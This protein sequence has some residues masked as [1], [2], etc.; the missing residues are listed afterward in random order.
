MNIQM[1]V[2]ADENFA[3]KHVKFFDA[4]GAE[5]QWEQVTKLNLVRQA[6]FIAAEY[7]RQRRIAERWQAMF[8]SSFGI[9]VFTIAMGVF[10]FL[11]NG[12]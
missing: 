3:P 11:W 2:E 7:F 5:I 10:Y 8:L 9:V 1:L 4:T 12:V 6:D